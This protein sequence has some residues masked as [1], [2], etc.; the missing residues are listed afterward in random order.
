MRLP[1]L[2]AVAGLAALA[3]GF[4]A[5]VTDATGCPVAF[6]GKC[7]CKK[8]RYFRW[9]PDEDTFVVN[10]TNTGFNSKAL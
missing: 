2:A 9:K 1:I 6:K 3:A 4:D 7:H 5:D 8:Q 10:C